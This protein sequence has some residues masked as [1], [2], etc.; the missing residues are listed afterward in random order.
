MIN[1]LKMAVVSCCLVVLAACGGAPIQNSAVELN[2]GAKVIVIAHHLVG[3]S[4][5]AGS[6]SFSVNEDDLTPYKMGV[7]GAADKAIENMDVLH[8]PVSPGDVSLRIRKGS[9]VLFDETIYISKG[10]TREVAL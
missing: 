8:L 4:V 5:Q 6:E 2:E 3:V 7:F 9:A 1:E 10:Q